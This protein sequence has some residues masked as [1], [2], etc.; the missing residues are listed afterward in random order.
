[1]LVFHI[2]ASAIHDLNNQYVGNT[3]EW[4]DVTE[5]RKRESDVARLQGMIDGAMTPIMMIDRDLNITYVNEATRKLLRSHESTMQSVYPGFSVNAIIGQNIDR[6]HKNPAHQ[7]QL[8]SDAN[9]LPYSTDIRVGPLTLN[10][11]ATAIM[12]AEGHYVG[13]ALEW[14]DVTQQRAKELDA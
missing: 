10:I 11:N 12:D 4:S 2:R 3:L 7:R 1:M 14:Q 5:L 9:N 6:F 8:L 13:S